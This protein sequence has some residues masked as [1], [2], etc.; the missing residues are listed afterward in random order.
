M[1][2]KNKRTKKSVKININEGMKTKKKAKTK[3]DEQVYNDII[4]PLETGTWKRE[5]KEAKL[6]QPE[7]L[8]EVAFLVPL[9][10]AV[11]L[12]P[13]VQVLGLSA[14]ATAVVYP[15]LKWAW[16]KL[17]KAHALT[18]NSKV[19]IAKCNANGG[20]MVFNHSAAIKTAAAYGAIGGGA[21]AGVGLHVG[22]VIGAAMGALTGY[23]TKR[24]DANPGKYWT[25]KGAKAPSPTPPVPTPPAPTTRCLPGQSF[26]APTGQCLTPKQIAA[27]G[28]GSAPAPTPPLPRPRRRSRSCGEPGTEYGQK[29]WTPGKDPSAKGDPEYDALY[30]D[31]GK[32]GLIGRLG[33]SG[34]D[35][36]WGPKHKRAYRKLLCKK[37]FA[38]APVTPEVVPEPEKPESQFALCTS[39]GPEVLAQWNERRFAYGLDNISVPGCEGTAYTRTGRFAGLTVAEIKEVWQKRTAKPEPA[40]PEPP[41]QDEQLAVETR[42]DAQSIYNYAD[43]FTSAAEE[44]A[45]TKIVRKHLANKTVGLLADFYIRVLRMEKATDRG[46]LVRELYHEDLPDLARDVRIAL[47]RPTRGARFRE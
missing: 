12:N 41:A 27:L 6:K 19:L 5:L 7:M 46:D 44:K 38:P 23:L 40:K 28:G 32:H 4:K 16:N 17:V 9:V 24:L 31:L 25:C 11:A 13:L 37:D 29:H 20:K 30:A 3:L 33:R 47:Q 15:P 34:T 42:E 2:T 1:S 21:G 10:G 22:A 39:V 8:N 45:I 35:Y 18:P 36:N 43:G 14:L 26:F